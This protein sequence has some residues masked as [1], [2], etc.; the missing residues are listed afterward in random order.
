[1]LNVLG[2]NIMVEGENGEDEPLNF[3]RAWDDSSNYVD[4]QRRLAEAAES[5]D[6]NLEIKF[7]TEFAVPWLRRDK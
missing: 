3:S 1:M 6:D 4:L 2:E 5:P 7:D